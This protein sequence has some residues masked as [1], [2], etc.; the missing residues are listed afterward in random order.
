L[1]RFLCP[2]LPTP[3]TRILLN[4]FKWDKEKLLEKYFDD[5]T[6]EFFKCA[7]VINPFNNATEAVRQ[8]VSP[9]LGFHFVA[10]LMHI[11]LFLYFRPHEV[12]AKSAKY[13][14]HY[15]RQM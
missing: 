6:E 1:S 10:H 12:S 11:P 4:H 9:E 5:N 3:I 15:Y 8:K 7:H 2:Q 13:V 14:F